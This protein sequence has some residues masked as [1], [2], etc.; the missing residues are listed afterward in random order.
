MGAH[1]RIA[2]LIDHLIIKHHPASTDVAPV[3]A[4]GMIKAGTFACDPAALCAFPQV[5]SANIQ[6]AG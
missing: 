1:H 6:L 2:V 5:A 4:V 3:A